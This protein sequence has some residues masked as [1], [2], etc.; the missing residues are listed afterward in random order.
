LPRISRRLLTDLL[1]GAA[2]VVAAMAMAPLGYSNGLLLFNAVM[3]LTL[4]QGINIIYGFTGYLPF[5][6]VGFFGTGAYGFAIAVLHLHCPPLAALA[7]AGAASVALGVVL[8]PLLR[9]SGA[10]FAIANLAASEAVYQ[11]VSNPDL[12]WLT[13]GPYG[14]TLSG[15]H[16]PAASY[17]TALVILAA[18]LGL[19]AG[20]RNSRFGLALQAI[21]DDVV[22]AGAAGIPV[23]RLRMAAWLLSALVAGLVGGAYAWVIGT[24]YPESVF[25]LGI[26][27]FA[28]VFTLFGGAAT[29]V[30]PV[31]GV[32]ILYGVYNGIGISV[33]QYFQLLYGALIVGLVLFLPNGLVSLLTRRGVRVP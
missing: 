26:S 9:L 14:I 28:I 20:L 23:V 12:Q 7:V 10:Y 3:F 29:L 22:S 2:P 32:A 27:I 31:L 24:F 18:A 25:D 30:G 11:V 17:G 21:K 1:F 16:D 8:T 19:V 5:G 33:P 15:V 4:A 13:N 6:Y